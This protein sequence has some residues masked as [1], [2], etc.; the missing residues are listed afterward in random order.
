MKANTTRAG[1][2]TR[3]Q[4]TRDINAPANGAPMAKAKLA[5][6]PIS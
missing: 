4:P 6:A 5:T 2:M 1:T 3:R